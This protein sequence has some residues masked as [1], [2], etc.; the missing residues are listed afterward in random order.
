MCMLKLLP[1]FLAFATQ[2]I[3]FSKSFS[4]LVANNNLKKYVKTRIF[5][6]NIFE[7]YIY[8]IWKKGK[9]SYSDS[10]FIEKYV[11][12]VNILIICQ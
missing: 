3:I 11:D 5:G 2:I 9:A 10:D 12:F 7:A 6:R 1:L 8:I 4:L